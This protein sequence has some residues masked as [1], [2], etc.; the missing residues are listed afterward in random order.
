MFSSIWLL[1]QAIILLIN[2]F[3]I[4]NEERFLRRSKK[5][6][7]KKFIPFQ[8]KVGFAY[9]PEQLSRRTIKTQ[10]ILFLNAIRTLLRSKKKK[11]KF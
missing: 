2:A 3:A 9:N 6:K 11:K 10:I 7:Q 5:K 1:L 4:L 8:T